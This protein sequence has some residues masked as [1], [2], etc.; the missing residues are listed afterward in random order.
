MQSGTWW[1]QWLRAAAIAF[2]NAAEKPSPVSDE[3]TSGKIVIKTPQP[4][5]QQE[6]K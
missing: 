1:G 6:K 3:A 2:L 4:Q 5:S